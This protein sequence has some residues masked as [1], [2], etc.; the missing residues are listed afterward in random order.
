MKGHDKH[1]KRFFFLYM[2][3]RTLY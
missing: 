3:S 2:C 1:I